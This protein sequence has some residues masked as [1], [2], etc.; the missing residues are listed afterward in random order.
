M[1]NKT[2]WKRLI[3]IN[4]MESDR[5]GRGKECHVENFVLFG[6]RIEVEINV[7]TRKKF[8]NLLNS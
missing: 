5:R 2:I 4:F 7:S 8:S 6:K 3:A 1:Y